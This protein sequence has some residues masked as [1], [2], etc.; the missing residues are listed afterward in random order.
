MRD[1]LVKFTLLVTLTAA[2]AVHAEPASR[3]FLNGVPTPVFFNDGDSFRV[4]DGVHKGTKARLAGFNTL[5]SFGPV[6]QWGTWTFKELY[7]IAKMATLN[8]RRGEWNCESDL[9]KDTYGRTLWFCKDLAVDQVRKGLAHAMSV[10]ADPARPELLAAQKEAIQNKQGMWA[11]GAPALVLTSLHSIAEGGGR[12][13]KT[14]NRVVS[15]VDGHSE[16]WIHTSRYGE[17]DKVCVEVP[18][19]GIA[20]VRALAQAMAG[21]TEVEAMFAPLNEDEQVRLLEAFWAVAPA[22]KDSALTGRIKAS[23]RKLVDDGTI[24]PGESRADSC[25][26]YVDFRRRFGGG[27]AVCLR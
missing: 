10:T 22:K 2:G 8:A 6:H 3:V 17:C 24:Q 21:D 11:H 19:L 9:K 25:H 13:G 18:K 16:P 20:D 26:I 15:S 5:E 27:K 1:N 12:D 23:L 7:V 4:L 14:Y